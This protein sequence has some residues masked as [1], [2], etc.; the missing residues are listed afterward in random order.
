MKVFMIRHGESETNRSG[1]WTGWLD[2]SLTEKGRAEAEAVGK[3]I[4]EIKFDKIYVSDLSRAVTTAEIAI[5]GCEYETLSILREI[6]VGSIA[7]QPLNVVRESEKAVLDK[8]GFRIFGGESRAELGDRVKAFREMLEGQN[9][10]YVAV[11]SHAG[12]IKKYLD[13][14]LGIDVSLKNIL[15]RN[16]S[17]AIFEYSDKSW[18]LHSW[19]NHY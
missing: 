13:A 7:G 2:V 6:N 10:D 11:F 3:L 12:F 18:Q 5:P 19:I 16:C 4:S 15:C 9:Y 14:V 17:L 8:D 1:S